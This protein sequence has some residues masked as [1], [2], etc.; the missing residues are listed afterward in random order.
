MRRIIIW[1]LTIMLGSA[2]WADVPASVSRAEDT[3]TEIHNYGVNAD[4]IITNVDELREFATNVANGNH[5]ADKTV[6]LVNDIAF[7]GKEGNFEPIGVFGGTFDGQGHTISGIHVKEDKSG[8]EYGGV[9][10]FRMLYNSTTVKN[11]ILK[12]CVFDGYNNVGAIA[13]TNA[14]I[15]L[16]CAVVDTQ[17]TCAGDTKIHI[18]GVCAQ[19]GSVIRNSYSLNNKIY[20][21]T[22]EGY[23]VNAGG[24]CGRN[25]EDALINEYA[26]IENCCNLSDVTSSNIANIGGIAGYNSDRIRNCYNVGTMSIENPKKNDYSMGGIA[27]FN[28]DVAEGVLSSYSL[29]GTVELFCQGYTL[30]DP[31]ETGNRLYPASYMQTAEFVNVLNEYVSNY[32]DL[33]YW[34]INEKT[35]YPLPTKEIFYINDCI[36]TLSDSTCIYD[37]KEQTPG[38]VLTY[39]GKTLAQDVD[40]T[41]EYKNNVNAGTATVIVAGKG[42]CRGTMSMDFEIQKAEQTFKYTE[43]YKKAYNSKAFKLNA[44]LQSGNGS[45]T[46]KSSNSKIASVSKNGKVTVKKIGTSVITITASETDNYKKTVIQIPITVSPKKLTIKTAK[47]SKN[48][49]NIRWEK[50]SK[51][52]GYEIQYS[53]NK[54]FKK[55]VTTVKV[56]NKSKV[57][58]TSKKVKKGKKYYVRVRAYKGNIYGTWS[59]VVVIRK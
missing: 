27:G 34:E 22:E 43:S 41:V 5:Y 37:G 23:V 19:N 3:G 44:K 31:V 55:G 59:K 51:A 54:N 39:N 4:L 7:D 8:Y 14:G 6:V 53:T 28:F 15:I 12:D 26:I 33:N 25:S 42:A 46:Y 18:G 16:N 32:S 52:K 50:D 57:S 48:K 21:I 58:Y 56:K 49:L 9:G 20:G 40:Y 17:I 11:L 10:F 13:G 30:M 45:M 35:S 47:A 29:E 24:I 2:L 38:V 1:F 36:M